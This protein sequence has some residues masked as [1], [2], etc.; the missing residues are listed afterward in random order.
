[1]D[2]S[3]IAQL[4]AASQ[5]LQEVRSTLNITEHVCGECGVKARSDYDEYS[6]G[7]MLGGAQTRIN[8]V[9]A[10]LTAKGVAK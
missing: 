7:E 9:V 3:R 6:A 2:D 1:M 4:Q 5:L 10:L 8:R